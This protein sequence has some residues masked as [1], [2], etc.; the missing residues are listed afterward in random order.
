MA[1]TRTRTRTQTALTRLATM[2]AEVH[3]EM[4]FVGRLLAQVEAGK[5]VFSGERA[6]ALGVKKAALEEKRQALH[7]TLGQFDPKILLTE[8]GLTR[9]L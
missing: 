9:V 7:L 5:A 6:K 8:S 1:L 2:V 3:G 4:E